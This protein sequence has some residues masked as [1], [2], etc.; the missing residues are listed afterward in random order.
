MNVTAVEQKLELNRRFKTDAGI[1]RSG[2]PTGPDGS[3][4]ANASAE[5]RMIDSSPGGQR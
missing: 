5:P 2:V 1:R 4:S 3:G